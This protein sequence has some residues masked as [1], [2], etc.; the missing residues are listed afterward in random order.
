MGSDSCPKKLEE[1]NSIDEA[2]EKRYVGFKPNT[3][4]FLIQNGEKSK[5]LFIITE[6]DEGEEFKIS[7]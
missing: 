3:E 7:Q 6:N 4:V 1:R 5:Y 2:L